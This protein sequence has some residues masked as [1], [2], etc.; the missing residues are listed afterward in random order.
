MSEMNQ[1]AGF[2]FV[3]GYAQKDEAGIHVFRHDVARGALKAAGS[4]AGLAA[5]DP[6]YRLRNERD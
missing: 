4:F 3:S 2:A 5:S 6:A 1:L